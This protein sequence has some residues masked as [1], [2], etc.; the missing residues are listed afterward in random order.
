MFPPQVRGIL[1]IIGLVIVAIVLASQFFE[2]PQASGKFI[3]T[4][5]SIQDA[6]PIP[7]ARVFLQPENGTRVPEGYTDKDGVAIFN[8]SSDLAGVVI[9]M[10]ISADGYKSSTTN[11]VLSKIDATYPIR[12]DPIP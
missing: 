2:P 6:S 5:A 4:V 3:V 1:A 9:G 11:F 10:S 12:L 7:N 8:L